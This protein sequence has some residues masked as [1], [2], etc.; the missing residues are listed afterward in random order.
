MNN[1]YTNGLEQGLRLIAQ[2]TTILNMK[3]YGKDT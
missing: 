2:T 1:Q 3:S